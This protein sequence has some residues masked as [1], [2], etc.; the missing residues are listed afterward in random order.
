MISE[1]KYN[2]K[3]SIASIQGNL[4]ITLNCQKCQ[5]CIKANSGTYYPC[6]KTLTSSSIINL[7]E[8]ELEN[9]YIY[10]SISGKKGYYY[11]SFSDSNSPKYIEQLEAE[12]CFKNCKFIF[13]LHNFYNYSNS[14]KIILFISDYEKVN[15]YYDF[16]NMNE[17]ENDEIENFNLTGDII[18]NENQNYSNKLFIDLNVSDI[19]RQEKYLRIHVKSK[20]DTYFNLVMNK[21]ISSPNIDEIK[22]SKNIIFMNANEEIRKNVITLDEDT[23]Y[24]ISL[25]LISGI[26]MISLDESG[27]YSYNL[28]Y[29]YQPEFSLFIRLHK[30][31]IS[32]MN[33]DKENNFTFFIN[34]TRIDDDEEIEEELYHQKNY[35]IRYFREKDNNIFPINII[36]DA[37]KQKN[38]TL[39]VNYRFIELEK[40]QAREKLYQTTDEG[41]IM[42]LTLGKNEE[43]NIAMLETQYYPEFRRGF[44]Y[45]DL[46]EDFDFQFIHLNIDKNYTNT[47]VYNNVFLEITPLFISKED[48]NKENDVEEEIYI[49]KNTYIQLDLNK[50]LNLIF[51]EPDLE[52]DNITI[53]IGNTSVIN[54][55]NNEEFNCSNN[56]GKIRCNP[57][58]YDLKKNYVMKLKPNHGAI[59]VKY[60]TKKGEFP[61]NYI[62][63][64][65]ISSNASKNGGLNSYELN[66]ENI[67]ISRGRLPPAYF[68]KIYFIRVYNYL[69]FFEE[70]EID[71]IIIK[72]NA[73][74][75]FR[76]EIT[77]EEFED[78]NIKFDI[79]FGVLDKKQFYISI[80]GA[81]Y[82]FD[83]V[84]Y[85]AYHSDTFRLSQ[86]GELIFE[87]NW[88]APLIIVI[89]IFVA[90]VSYIVIRFIQKRN[91]K[92]K[93]VQDL[94]NDNVL[95]NETEKKK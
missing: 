85:I 73:I 93:K 32:S 71:N 1:K 91:A 57:I 21:F 77:S 48:L 7:S 49:P 56:K 17:F 25:H 59:L 89:L 88:I 43:S 61:Y 84:E 82:Y 16:I 36:I 79:S 40:N 20:E 33:Y 2:Y 53:D 66:F 63:N 75:S 12:P 55:T 31:S 28:S 37:E 86:S 35:K 95:V 9:E 62:N 13:P 24:K 80:I 94:I 46:P 69:D 38:K 64:Y 65:N 6:L 26:G 74:L 78:E 23:L 45:F 87:E 47:F 19:M 76:K 44:A 50:S 41:F 83:S 15:I 52:Y 14:E 11:F 81:V 3:T 92:R 51:S 70:K 10:Y 8:L 5:M 67:K 18:S 4:I 60:T 30:F 34:T 27:K 42:N 29:E 90:S 72:N 22:Y 68:K 58:Y 39:L 54:I